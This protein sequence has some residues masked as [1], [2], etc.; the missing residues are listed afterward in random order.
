MMEARRAVVLS[1]VTGWVKRMASVRE[2]EA[3]QA[4]RKAEGREE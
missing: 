3:N 2:V 1:Q 4:N